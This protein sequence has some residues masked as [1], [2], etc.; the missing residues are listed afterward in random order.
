MLILKNPLEI[1]FFLQVKQFL[2]EVPHDLQYAKGTG[3]GGQRDGD[4][5]VTPPQCIPVF[6]RAK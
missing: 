1:D 2:S 5:G 3:N 6:L 4:S